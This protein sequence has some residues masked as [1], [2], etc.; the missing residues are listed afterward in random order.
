MRTWTD[1]EKCEGQDGEAMPA[2]QREEWVEKATMVAPSSFKPAQPNSWLAGL[3]RNRRSVGKGGGGTLRFEREDLIEKVIV[4]VVSMFETPQPNS[5]L[6]GLGR[7][8]KSVR[9]GGE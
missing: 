5:W 7:G 1:V 9:E 2:F 3:E 6:A 4:V 8:R